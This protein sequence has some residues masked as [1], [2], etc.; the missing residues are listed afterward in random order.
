MNSKILINN[1]LIWL[2]NQ[3]VILSETFPYRFLGLDKAHFVKVLHYFTDSTKNPMTQCLYAA[4][5]NLFLCF[6][7]LASCHHRP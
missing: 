4:R 2:F 6:L 1:L 7:A 5:L 3:T